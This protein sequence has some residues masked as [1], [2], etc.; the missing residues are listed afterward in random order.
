MLAADSDGG[1]VATNPCWTQILGW[2]EAE[3]RAKKFRDLVHPDDLQKTIEHTISLTEGSAGGWLE[4]RCRHKDGSYRRISWSTFAA[5]KSVYAIG[6]AMGCTTQGAKLTES[7]EETNRQAM[8]SVSRFA[9]ILAHDFNNLLQGMAGSMELVRKLI[10]MDRTAETQ[11]FID[12]ALASIRRAAGFTE[13]LHVF[14]DRRPANPAVVDIN[15]TIRSME[16][17]VRRALT[18]SIG[19]RLALAE[20][21]WQTW[22]DPKQLENAI[23]HLVTNARDAMPEGGTLSIESGNMSMDDARSEAIAPDEYVCIAVRDTGTGMSEEI[24]RQAFEPLF[25]TKR[26]GPGS[27]L[28]LATVFGFARQLQGY[29]RIQSEVGRGTTVKLYLPRYRGNNAGSGNKDD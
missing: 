28:G 19:L 13:R 10:E 26:S 9:G 25:T 3:L 20:D 6:R 24:V 14:S 23:M 4:N 21:L 11:R 8:E 2:E 16:E 22:C 1:I 18:P 17:P 15:G 27:G 7:M 5:G 29:A 12:N